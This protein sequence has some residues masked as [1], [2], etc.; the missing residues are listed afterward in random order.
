[1]KSI[2]N[3]VG[4]I[5][6]KK[7]WEGMSNKK[8]YE[9]VQKIPKFTQKKQ[10]KSRRRLS[11]LHK[12]PEAEP[13]SVRVSESAKA[14]RSPLDTMST[15]T[16]AKP[17]IAIGPSVETRSELVQLA[18]NAGM[19]LTP[20]PKDN[21]DYFYTEGYK[22][23][24]SIED[25]EL[26]ARKVLG[27]LKTL[28]KQYP[29]DTNTYARMQD[30]IYFVEY[31]LEGKVTNFT[32]STLKPTFFDTITKNF[33]TNAEIIPQRLYTLYLF[34]QQCV[35]LASLEP[36]VAER[37]RRA[38]LRY[39]NGT[40]GATQLAYHRLY[41]ETGSSG[42]MFLDLLKMF[43]N[44][45]VK[46]TGPCTLFRYEEFENVQM[47][48]EQG[49][50]LNY[51]KK[52]ENN[53]TNK[54]PLSEEE[55][56][57]KKTDFKKRSI[58]KAVML[59]YDDV[60]PQ[61]ILEPENHL[62]Y[63]IKDL[64]GKGPRPILL[65]PH[66]SIIAYGDNGSGTHTIKTKITPDT[67][68]KDLMDF[69][70]I[71]FRSGTAWFVNNR[72]GT[73]DQG[74][75]R[76]KHE[77]IFE[78]P[79]IL[80]TSIVRL[81]GDVVYKSELQYKPPENMLLDKLQWS[82]ALYNYTISSKTSIPCI[83]NYYRS[84]KNTGQ[85]YEIMLPPGLQARN[86]GNISKSPKLDLYEYEIFNYDPS[87]VKKLLRLKG[88]NIR[89]SVDNKRGR[90]VRYYPNSKEVVVETQIRLDEI[91]LID[92][93][94]RIAGI[95]SR[96][97]ILRQIVPQSE[98][99]AKSRSK[100]RSKS[101]PKRKSIRRAKSEPLRPSFECDTCGETSTNLKRIGDDIMCE[102]CRKEMPAVL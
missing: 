100:S 3:E 12:T 81:G 2:L 65:T 51:V 18:I 88:V 46:I 55:W 37:Y 98:R 31:F 45:P 56:E 48:G 70:D 43:S 102:W 7:A 28:Q 69:F 14:R 4:G 35:W 10:E 23:K 5:L 15:T 52:D 38:L 9:I 83:F 6:K 21:S 29:Q 42:D 53:K 99:R 33:N 34:Y 20:K 90:I 1:M 24:F 75:L 78:Q 30:E 82:N 50:Y 86:K 64:I 58:K 77:Y 67:S 62:N 47:L 76:R 96:K 25:V 61:Q 36:A 32:H 85:E 87:F 73:V 49:H 39:K 11:D 17:T 54:R 63:V 95:K 89:F 74:K 13:V 22:Y 97:S 94:T 72:L 92:E 8:I 59:L 40:D 71:L 60:N 80:S 66:R 16:L 19:S 26:Y 57:K 93:Y 27:D 68:V 84:G 79:Y 101:V 41:N 91:D 44:T